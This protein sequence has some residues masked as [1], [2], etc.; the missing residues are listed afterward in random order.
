MQSYGPAQASDYAKA[1]L[2]GFV[3]GFSER[4]IPDALQTFAKR[5]K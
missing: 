2:W 5:L 4:L 3:A 1:L